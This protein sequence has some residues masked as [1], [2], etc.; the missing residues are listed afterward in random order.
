[1]ETQESILEPEEAIKNKTNRVIDSNDLETARLSHA[2]LHVWISI[3]WHEQGIE[4]KR[5]NQ[6]KV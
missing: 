3:I 1:L 5:Q 2:A 6:N 4:N